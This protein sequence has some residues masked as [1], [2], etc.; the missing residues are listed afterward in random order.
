LNRPNLQ[1]RT[2]AHVRR[3]L[4]EDH[5]AVGIEYRRG[6]DVRRA[7][8]TT[9]VVLAAGAVNTPCLLQHSGIGPEN[10]LR[11][12]GIAVL[13]QNEGVGR[14]L[15]DHL[16]ISYFYKAT[17]PTLN[18]S[19]G[20][21][22]GRLA[23]GTR[24]LLSRSGPLSLSVN[25]IGGLVRT[26]PDLRRPDA[27]LYFSPVSYST[28][29]NGKKQ[30]LHPDP[31]PG[32]I[33][34]FNSCRPTSTGRVEIA[35]GD[36]DAGPKIFPNYLATDRDVHDVVSCARLIGRLQETHAMRSLIAEQPTCDPARASDSEIVADFRNRGNT[37]YHPCG[38][39]RMA[40]E[41][42]GGVVD[43][44]LKVYGVEGL[45]LADASIFPNITSA[46]TNAP[47]IMVAHKAAQLI[48]EE[49]SELS[50]RP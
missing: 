49:C 8:A 4:F 25:Q 18:Q 28:E 5:R 21:W 14:G 32:F 27:Q 39:C 30:M 44:A 31:F 40:P 9:Q 43:A 15:Q 7:Y 17:E 11:D 35:T 12:K 2:G 34:A 41:N 10:V 24:F 38:T 6:G 13:Y 23:S 3:V 46:N 29:V 33:M 47:T 16:G 19:L 1:V 22:Q 42:Q 37:V 50:R 48:A 45:R 36:L 20:T 26:S